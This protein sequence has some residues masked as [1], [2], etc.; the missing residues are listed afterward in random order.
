MMRSTLVMD[1]V[2]GAGAL[3]E[4]YTDSD[5]RILYGSNGKDFSKEA[6]YILSRV[7]GPK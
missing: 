3:R 4:V 1:L 2:F 7:F 6:I 5:L